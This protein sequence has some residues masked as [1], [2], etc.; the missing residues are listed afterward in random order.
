MDITTCVVRGNKQH[1][2]SLRTS[3]THSVLTIID[4]SLTSTTLSVVSCVFV[5]EQA[6]ALINGGPAAAA[7][8]EKRLVGQPL[9]LLGDKTSIA[10]KVRLPLRFLGDIADKVRLPPPLGRHDHHRSRG[11][12]FR[13]CVRACARLVLSPPH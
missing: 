6:E 4:H 3:R 5:C 12:S 2:A 11:L 8:V 10:D 1:K 9:R 7:D 13:I